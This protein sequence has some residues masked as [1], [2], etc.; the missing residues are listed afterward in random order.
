MRPR[1][2]RPASRVPAPSRRWQ[3]RVAG[4]GWL[5]R[6]PAE[7]GRATA[8]QRES[9]GVWGLR[10]TEDHPARRRRG[11]GAISSACG[12]VLAPP[13]GGGRA[14]AWEGRLGPAATPAAGP[15]Q[16]RPHTQTPGA[17]VCCHDNSRHPSPGRPRLQGVTESQFAATGTRAGPHG[18]HTWLFGF[19]LKL[20]V[21][22]SH[23][24]LL[25][26]ASHAP[27]APVTCADALDRAEVCPPARE[28]LLDR[29]GLGQEQ[30]QKPQPLGGSSGGDTSPPCP[31][32][33]V[34]S[35]GL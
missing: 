31:Q 13:P 9:P 8:D 5:G 34:G 7:G 26:H 17:S 23:F 27:R 10:W 25:G 24:Q 21:T 35:P 18:S 3:H 4:R 32:G 11:E 14:Q 1:V 29:A 28:A 2:P 20:H 16:P 15:R 19:N 6:R 33:G 12:R 22:R 30:E